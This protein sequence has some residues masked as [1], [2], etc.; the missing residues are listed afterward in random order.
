MLKNLWSKVKAFFVNL[1]VKIQR[2]FKHAQMWIMSHK[3]AVLSVMQLKDKWN[4]SSNTKK[5]DIVFKAIARI[6]LFA[7]TTGFMYLM[8]HLSVTKLGIFF[9]SKIPVTAMVVLIFVLTLFEGISIL[10]GMTNALYFSKDNSVLITYPVKA[11]D[12]FLSKVIVYYIDA[13]K[14]SCVLLLP[15][16]VAFGLIYGYSL[17]YYLWIIILMLIYVALIVLVS[18][19]LSIPTYFVMKFLKKYT[20]VKLIASAVMMGFVVWGVIELVNVIPENINLIK[21]Y[22]KFSLGV[23][24]FLKWFS[25]TFKISSAITSMFC[26]VRKGVTVKAM[27]WYSLI[28]PVCLIIANIGLVFVNMFVSR[29]FYTKMISANSQKNA[30]SKKEKKNVKLNKY[31]SIYKY[32]LLRILRNEKQVASTV[33]TIIA[34][35]LV[36]LLANRVYGSISLSLFG[37]KLTSIFNYFFVLLLALSHNI[38]ASHIYSKDG[39]SWTVNKTMPVDPRK[40]LTARI[41]YNIVSSILIIVPGVIIYASKNEQITGFATALIIFSMILFST[42]HCLL[43]ASYDF[44]NSKNKDKADIGSE[45]ISTHENMSLLFG[46]ILCVVAVLFIFILNQTTMSLPRV[47]LAT[48]IYLRVVLF[49]LLLV[50]VEIY[51]FCKKIKAT[52]QEN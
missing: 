34:V 50:V 52:Y 4:I 39:P 27:S 24:N 10:I 12:L 19:V 2:I 33:I 5:K 46:F 13:L 25:N 3:I 23:N 26:G 14:K 42:F 15:T 44:S 21:T 22:A 47:S 40:S 18:A 32:E 20:I 49:G 43:S 16:I 41:L 29:P 7:C 9:S 37:I 45:I 1:F 28:V 51:M 31:A 38:T 36:I 17:P 35:P 48:R 30:N 11:S 8:M 6:I